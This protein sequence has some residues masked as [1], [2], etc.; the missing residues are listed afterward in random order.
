MRAKALIV[1]LFLAFLIAP[2]RITSGTAFG[3]AVDCLDS[4]SA[5]TGYHWIHLGEKRTCPTV[6]STGVGGSTSSSGPRIETVD[7]GRVKVGVISE[8]S[9]NHFCAAVQGSCSVQSRAQAPADPK[10]TTVGF[11]QQN[12]SGT[13]E[14]N[15]FDCNVVPGAGPPPPPQVTPFDAYAAV[16]K[17]V[18]SPA[19]GVAPGKGRTL[20]NMETIFWVNSAADQSLGPVTLLGHQVGLRIHARAAAWAFGD[21]STDT[22]AGL[23]RPYAAADGCGEAVCAGYFGHTYVSTGEMTV[24]ATVTWAGEFSVD[25][26]PWRGIANPAT[27]ANTVEGPAA[28]RPIT[29]IQARGVLVQDPG[30]FTAYPD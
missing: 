27:G 21:G 9:P 5:T 19:I 8:N 24:S 22:S 16:L 15:G 17:L 11:V 30:G 20:V 26:G 10:A 23:G 1:I 12:P 13:W 4:T 14:L 3:N 6:E 25:G 18:P 28:T 2:S 29:V 7:C